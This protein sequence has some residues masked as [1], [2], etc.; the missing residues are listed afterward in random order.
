M[1]NA[2]VGYDPRIDRLASGRPFAFLHRHAV[3]DARGQ[4]AVPPY[5]AYRNP[6]F[7]R[8]DFRLEKTWRV[9]ESGS[10]AFVLEGQNVTL[11]KE[12]SGLGLDCEGKGSAAQ[13]ETNTCKHGDNRPDHHPERGRRGIFLTFVESG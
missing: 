5:N 8:L 9:G 10:V 1:L 11:R 12:V 3:L 2:I 13:G 6:A 4:P 7:Y